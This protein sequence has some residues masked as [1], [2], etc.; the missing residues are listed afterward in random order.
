MTFPWCDETTETYA[1]STLNGAAPEC[2]EYGMDGYSGSDRDDETNRNPKPQ[3]S[4]K[5]KLKSDRSLLPR[6][7]YSTFTSC[8]TGVGACSLAC[9][10][11]SLLY[12]QLI[13]IQI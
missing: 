9:T 7:V 5:L 3:F 13:L 4:L 2:M 12:M 11:V 1:S 10:S 8:S 6:L